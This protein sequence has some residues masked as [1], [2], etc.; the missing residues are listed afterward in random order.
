[1]V[2]EKLAWIRVSVYSMKQIAG[3]DFNRLSV[4]KSLSY[5][6]GP[7]DDPK[8]TSM[9]FAVRNNLPVRLA[10]EQPSDPE[11]DI[12]AEVAVKHYGEPFSLPGKSAAF[13]S[14]CYMPW[15]RAAV[16][17]TGHFL[18]VPSVMLVPGS[19][20][21]VADCFRLCHVRDL[22]RW[23]QNNRPHDMGFKCG[24]CNCGKEHNEFLH[25]MLSE[26]NDVEF[27]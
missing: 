16:D 22:E 10:V 15:I 5:I 2:L 26:V 27:V 13:P 23:F 21:K 24:F 4:P 11:D 17:W 8:K 12:C 3:I 9:S 18:A 25:G 14:G 1:M 7:M 19:V 20:G 6:L